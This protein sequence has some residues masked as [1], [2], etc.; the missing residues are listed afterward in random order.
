MPRP[1]SEVRL[2]EGSERFLK[3]RAYTIYSKWVNG[4]PS[5]GVGEYVRVLYRGELVGYGFYEKIGAVGL[6]LLAYVGEDPPE[7]LEELI[8]W[9]LEAA[10]ARRKMSRESEESGYRLVYADSD[11]MPGLVVD[12]YNDV[13]VVQSTSWGW[14]KHAELLARSLVEVTGCRRVY[15]KN[16]QRAR[17]TFGMPIFSGFLMGEGPPE[18]VIIEGSARFLVDL[19]RGHKTGFYLDQREARLRLSRMKLDG[20]SVLDLFSYTGAFAIHALLAG[21]SH[22]VMVE[23]DLDALE[24][25]QRNLAMNGLEGRGMPLRARVE[26]L[27]DSLVAKRRKFDVVISDPP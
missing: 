10:L 18:T 16:D 15:L 6:R 26:R 5:L 2:L 9:R 11:G 7:D 19:A 4:D 21:A 20:M 1:V 25:M 8:A 27:L 14:D 23:E 24:V 22:A 3:S 13:A 12:V 17:K